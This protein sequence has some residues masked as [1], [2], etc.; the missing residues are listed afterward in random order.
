VAS[1]A[2][3]AGSQL[4]HG[5]VG[6][7]R[8]VIGR[9]IPVHSVTF[10]DAVYPCGNKVPLKKTDA[11]DHLSTFHRGSPPTRA[12]NGLKGVWSPAT[13]AFQLTPCPLGT[14]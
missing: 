12:P 2:D 8:E 10:V 14:A 11:K 3:S 9:R 7:R 1:M 6:G 4:F 5:H 13:H